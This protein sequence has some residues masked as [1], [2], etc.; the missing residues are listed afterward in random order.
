M[1][2]FEKNLEKSDLKWKEDSEKRDLQWK[3][4]S[5]K[6]DNRFYEL[7]QEMHRTD[8]RLALTEDHI[9]NLK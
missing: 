3:E 2:R 4:T 6:A 5:E 1:K 7:L 9:S 8:T